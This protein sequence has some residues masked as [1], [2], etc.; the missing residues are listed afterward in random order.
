MAEPENI[1]G[2]VN[3][4]SQDGRGN[5]WIASENALYQAQTSVSKDAIPEL[6]ISEN[7]LSERRLFNFRCKPAII[8][9][10]RK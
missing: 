4:L 1:T 2:K 6:M 7:F 8:F 5:L 3:E 9:M 10:I